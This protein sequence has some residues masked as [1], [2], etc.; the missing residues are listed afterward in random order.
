MVAGN[1]TIDISSSYVGQATI[2]T[3]G[4]ITTG[5]WTGTVIAAVNGGTGL[6]TYAVGDLISPNTTTTSSRIAVASGSVLTCW[7][8]YAS[9]LGTLATTDLTDAVQ[10]GMLN[11]TE[12]VSGTS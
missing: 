10:I 8:V 11:Q 2:A 9:Y 4:T 5:T 12:T 7:C 3:L 6:T 1:P